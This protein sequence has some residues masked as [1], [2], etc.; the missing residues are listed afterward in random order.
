MS[1][2][3]LVVVFGSTGAQGGSVANSLLGTDR[4]R[5]RALTR[6]VNSEK[7]KELA[8]KGAEVFKCD[9]FEKKEIEN[10][11]QGAE[12][13]YSIVGKGVHE[14]ERLGKL[15]ADIAKAAGIKWIIYS[16]FPDLATESNGKYPTI[17]LTGKNY[18]EKYIKTLG[19]PNVTFVYL[20]YYANNFERIVYKEQKDNGD[21]EIALPYLKEDDVLAIIDVDDL[22][23]AKWN[24]KAIPIASEYVNMKHIIDCL[25]KASGKRHILKTLDDESIKKGYPRYNQEIREMY[26]W[27][28]EFD[29]FGKDKSN[30]DIS[31]V[32]QLHPNILSYEQYVKKAYEKK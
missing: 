31:I 17:N 27:I 32:K 9:L 22:G 20:G 21:V 15:I 25:T 7:A 4:Y 11:L 23:P 28:K 8:A 12:I 16:S 26:G 30:G 5:V 3:P 2:K 19:I 13:A 10:A 18:V 14:E 6:N 29:F 24:G 1:Q